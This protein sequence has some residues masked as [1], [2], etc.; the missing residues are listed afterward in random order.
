MARWTVPSAL[1]IALGCLSF[2]GMWVLFSA[3]YC[4][5]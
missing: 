1:G 2:Y 3:P 4:Y 5:R